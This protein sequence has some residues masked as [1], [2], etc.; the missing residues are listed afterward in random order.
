M[1]LSQD[2]ADFFSLPGILRI[3]E[4]FQFLRNTSAI[5]AKVK[6]GCRLPTFLSRYSAAVFRRLKL[7]KYGM[8]VILIRLS[9]AEH[10]KYTGIQIKQRRTQERC[11]LKRIIRM[12]MTV[13][14]PVFFQE[15]SHFFLTGN[16]MRFFDG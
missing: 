15:P 9:Y 7:K 1:T 12:F 4:Y 10:L 8:P 5:F 16:K 3:S 2:A 14:K 11:V 6:K 13:P